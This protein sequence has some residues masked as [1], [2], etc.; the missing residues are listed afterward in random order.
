MI[1]LNLLGFFSFDLS[2]CKLKY[3]NIYKLA[4]SGIMLSSKS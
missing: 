4:C 2:R 1:S 3:S